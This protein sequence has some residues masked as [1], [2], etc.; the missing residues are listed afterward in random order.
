[1]SND[2]VLILTHLNEITVGKIESYLKEMGQ[3]TVRV[4]TD[5]LFQAGLRLNLSLSQQGLGGR[6]KFRDSSFDIKDI[7]SVWYR[8]PKKF[9]VPP[10][11]E[12]TEEEREFV[13]SEFRAALWSLYTTIDC[14]W[15]NKPLQAVR[16]FEHNKLLQLKVAS[17][18][19]LAVPETLISNDPGELIGFA[20]KLGGVIAVKVI[21]SRIFQESHLSWGIYTN[22]VLVNFLK[23][24]ERDL[25][26]APIMAQEYVPKK[27]ELRV[28]IVGA[29]V[30]ACAIHSQE[31]EKTTD[32]WRHY[33]FDNVPHES[34]Q[35]PEEIKEKLLA[36]MNAA[37]LSFGAIDMVV[38][39]DGEFVF[40]E[41]NPSGQF[42]WI[43]NITGLPIS[44]A[45][46]ETLAHP[47]IG[48]KN[49]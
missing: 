20:E 14:F 18:V 19:G 31:S 4:N 13:E 12:G 49:K 29:N 43:E 21:C 24:H 26:I 2:A 22:K 45:I 5:E 40:L 41:I 10:D 27:F 1:M 39:P 38:K 32:D 34:Y 30:F 47:P 46:A 44:K 28:T 33:D 11:H 25:V 7:K 3:R 17:S 37:D 6:I 8:R 35:L 9:V 48:N 42:S 23:E 16:L 15:M 36:F